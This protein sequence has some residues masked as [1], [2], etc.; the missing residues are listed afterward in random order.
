MTKYTLT[1]E[2]CDGATRVIANMDFATYT[3]VRALCSRTQEL[4][5]GCYPTMEIRESI[6]K[7]EEG[8][9]PWFTDD[10]IPVQD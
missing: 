9:S 6:G 7:D 8:S 3:L 1:L 10:D 2:A 5:G 4:G